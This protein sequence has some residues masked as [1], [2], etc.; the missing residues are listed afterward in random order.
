MDE[1]LNGG[2]SFTMLLTLL[3]IGFKIGGVINWSWLWVLAP[4]WIP[5]CLAIFICFLLL[6]ISLFAD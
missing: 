2:A 6:L 4:M 1:K 3:F 5:T